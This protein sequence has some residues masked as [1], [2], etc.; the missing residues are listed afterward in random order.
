MALSFGS[1]KFGGGG[2]SPWSQ[3]SGS[4]RLMGLGDAF[5]GNT[6]DLQSLLAQI[7][8]PG[9]IGVPTTAPMA[10][11]QVGQQP[12]GNPFGDLLARFGG[13]AGGG[14]GGGGMPTMGLASA[15]PLGLASLALP[16]SMRRKFGFGGGS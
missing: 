5:S 10:A 3:M 8:A 13:V 1:M 16:G 12:G 4:Q 7:R 14:I 15:A 11:P 6:G 9:A 2:P